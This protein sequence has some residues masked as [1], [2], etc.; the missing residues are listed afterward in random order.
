MEVGGGRPA[1]LTNGKFEQNAACS[2][3]GKFFVYTTL[4]NGKQLLMEKG[5]EGGEAK[6]LS[7][8]FVFSSAISPG[9]Q[10]V[11]F[12]SVEGT[13]VQTKV[14]IKVIPASG[15]APIKVFDVPVMAP[16]RLQFSNDGKALYYPINEKGVSNLVSQPMD[17]G[18]PTP[19]TDFKELTFYGYAYNWPANKLAV[20]RGKLNSDVVIITQQ[21]AQ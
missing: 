13:G 2:P 7:D 3:D 10:Q 18:P 20:T 4:V 6:Q 15:G 21:A 5:M 17:G 9:G 14:V 1:P 11:A 12:F 19:V 16:G 8:D